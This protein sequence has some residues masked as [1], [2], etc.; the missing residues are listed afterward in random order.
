MTNRTMNIALLGVF[1][2]L[3]ACK[4]GKSVP[5]PKN[6]PNA[7]DGNQVNPNQGGNSG[8]VDVGPDASVV[9]EH[10]FLTA[11]DMTKPATVELI[12]QANLAA[13]LAGSDVFYYGKGSSA[14]GTL[15]Q[16]VFRPL[17]GYAA[18][19]TSS[20]VTFSADVT[21][22]QCSVGQGYALKGG[23]LKVLLNFTC[24]AGNL[25]QFNGAKWR[26]ISSLDLACPSGTGT[27]LRNA[28]FTG[29]IVNDKNLDIPTEMVWGM[30]TSGSE[31]CGFSV[32]GLN[33]T[34][35]DGCVKFY[36]SSMNMPT[37]LLA[38]FISGSFR[39]IVA[40]HGGRFFS[41]GQ[42]ETV[43]NNWSGTVT[44]SGPSTSPTY[45]MSGNGANA[46]GQ[47]AP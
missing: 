43:A 18:T 30:A 31:A 38:D 12:P 46:T 39:N 16:C 2:A 25:S 44:Y 29:T 3:L 28:K 20:S 1:C 32:T 33:R 9:P 14:G 37:G 22:G 5:V 21:V 36:R 15:A 6:P 11:I 27:V 4:P 47:I 45:Q 8:N 41:K 17:D 7:G 40:D 34:F 42:M 10:G 19:A 24:G 35:D 23:T 13:K 26:D